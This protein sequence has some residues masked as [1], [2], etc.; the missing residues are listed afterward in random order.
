MERISEF[1]APREDGIASKELI[2]TGVEGRA[3]AVREG[4]NHMINGGY[5]T[6]HR[7]YKLLKP[8][9]PDA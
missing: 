1:L 4:L 3:A 8:Y 2:E 7:P 5:V 9:P 6:D